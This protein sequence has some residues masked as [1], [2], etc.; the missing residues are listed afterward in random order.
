[1]SPSRWSSTPDVVRAIEYD[2]RWQARSEAGLSVHGEAEFVYGFEPKSVLDAG[3]GTGRVAIELAAKGV[4]V[5]GVDLDE[6]M[7][8]VARGNAPNLPWVK[9]DLVNLD[10]ERKFDV[11]VLAGNVMIFLAPDTE[12]MVVRRM[13]DHLRPTGLLVAGFSI[14]PGGFGVD[15][16]EIAAAGAGLT[17]A[18]RWSTWERAPYCEGDYV[19]SIHRR[20]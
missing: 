12:E 20:E 10:L 6:N 5:V 16:Y 13:A 3:C 19:V 9:G 4:E 8:S 14:K 17:R 7:L 2:Q 11:V 15:E 1:L 18:G